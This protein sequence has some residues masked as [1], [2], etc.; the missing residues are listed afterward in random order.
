[1]LELE[2]NAE[3]MEHARNFRVIFELKD[4][5]KEFVN[6]DGSTIFMAQMCS[7]HE[8]VAKLSAQIQ[9]YREV[10]HEMKVEIVDLVARFSVDSNHE[11]FN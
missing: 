10:A 4:D 1:M 6:H 3:D 8:Q 9:S 5:E 2:C 7:T 11:T